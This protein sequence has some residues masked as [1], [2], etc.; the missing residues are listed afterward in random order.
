MDARVAVALLRQPG[1]RVRVAV[2]DVARL[3][4]LDPV[5]QPLEADV[6]RVVGVVVDA[7]RGQWQSST[8]AAGRRRASRDALRCV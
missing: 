8:S 6:G 4:A 5:A 7:E 2:E 1:D 3:V